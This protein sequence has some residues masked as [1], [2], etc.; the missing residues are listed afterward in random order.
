MFVTD[1]FIIRNNVMRIY[2]AAGEPTERDVNLLKFLK[3]QAALAL[4]VAAREENQEEYKI[5]KEDF[6]RLQREQLVNN[7]EFIHKITGWLTKLKS[8][9]SASMKTST[10]PLPALAILPYNVFEEPPAVAP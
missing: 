10:L 3:V 2:L 1:N 7:Q 8:N 5:A 6:Q 9:F 4:I